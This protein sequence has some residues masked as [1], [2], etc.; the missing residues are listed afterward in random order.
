MWVAV[1]AFIIITTLF[2]CNAFDMGGGEGTGFLP[3]VHESGLS[4]QQTGLATVSNGP[5]V[6]REIVSALPISTGYSTMGS[7]L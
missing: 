4:F 2:R 5:H 3:S 7:A 6:E 1:V